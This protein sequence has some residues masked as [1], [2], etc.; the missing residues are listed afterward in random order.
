MLSFLYTVGALSFCVFSSVDYSGIT[1][2]LTLLPVAASFYL[3]LRQ[4]QGPQAAAI[5]ACCSKARTVLHYELRLQS[6][7]C[8]PNL[9]VFPL[10]L[11]TGSKFHSTL[12]V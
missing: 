10:H 12:G 11:L 1:L 8:L 4:L 2:A 9:P 6:R 3:S 5:I 7:L